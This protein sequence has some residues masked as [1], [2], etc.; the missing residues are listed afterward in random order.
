MPRGRPAGVT[1]NK[2][3]YSLYR[4]LHDAFDTRQPTGNLYDMMK[5]MIAIRNRA[6]R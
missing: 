3:L 1:I 4:R 6:R 2:A 5:E